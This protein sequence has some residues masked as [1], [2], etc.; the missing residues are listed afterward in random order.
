MHRRWLGNHH[1]HVSAIGLGCW[2]MSHAY[3]P[4]DEDESMAT[5]EKALDVGINFFDTADVY[6]GGHNE[7]LIA[8]MLKGY[9]NEMVIATKFD[10]LKN[11]KERQRSLAAIREHLI[12]GEPVLF[13]AVTGQGASEIWQAIRRTP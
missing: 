2:G 1:L 8:R 5:M 3:G 4:A 11:Q 10:K 13:S 6:G 12:D 9:R 7:S